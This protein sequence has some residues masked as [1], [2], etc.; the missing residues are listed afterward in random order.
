MQRIKLCFKLYKSRK[1]F[2]CPMDYK[3]HLNVNGDIFKFLQRKVAN[4]FDYFLTIINLD[5]F[6]TLLVL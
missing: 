2:E 6:Q 1:V 5:Y 3:K 4:K